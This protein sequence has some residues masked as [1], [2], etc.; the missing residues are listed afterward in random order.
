V[1]VGL[2]LFL[3]GQ[4]VPLKGCIFRATAAFFRFPDPLSSSK[5]RR[6]SGKSPRVWLRFNG[7]LYVG[8]HPAKTEGKGEPRSQSPKQPGLANLQLYCKIHLQPC[9]TPGLH[10]FPLSRPMPNNTLSLLHIL[11]WLGLFFPWHVTCLTILSQV[12]KSLHLQKNVGMPRPLAGELHFW[13][14]LV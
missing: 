4:E 8:A 9:N 2:L 12:G 6:R 10:G 7:S 11:N 1:R 13:L 5:I 3:P 14:F